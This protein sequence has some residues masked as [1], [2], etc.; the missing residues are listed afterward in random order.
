MIYHSAKEIVMLQTSDGRVTVIM[1]N[2]DTVI[3]TSKEIVDQWLKTLEILI[4]AQSM[5]TLQKAADHL[6]LL[7]ELSRDRN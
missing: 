7:Y 6:N 4:D 2:K 5:P 3:S 1:P